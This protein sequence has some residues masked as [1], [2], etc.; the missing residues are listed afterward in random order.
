MLTME[1]T[2]KSNIASLRNNYGG[3]KQIAFWDKFATVIFGFNVILI[4][5]GVIVGIFLICAGMSA[6][7]GEMAVPIIL[8]IVIGIIVGV[9]LIFFQY[10]LLML[11]QLFLSYLYDVK[12]QRIA[13]ENLTL[14]KGGEALDNSTLETFAT[15]TE[16]ETMNIDTSDIAK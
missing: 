13:I 9:A 16:M 4:T 8:T 11:I 14:I 7:D 6:L 3:F 2:S 15:I 5:C 12:Q 10:I 1:E